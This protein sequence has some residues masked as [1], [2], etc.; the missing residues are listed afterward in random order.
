MSVLDEN[1]PA[2]QRLLLRKWRVQFRV[3]GV[4]VALSGTSDENLIPALARLGALDLFQPASQTALTL[5]LHKIPL[6]TFC[7]ICNKRLSG[8]FRVFDRRSFPVVLSQRAKRTSTTVSVAA[9]AVPPG[10]SAA[11]ETELNG[12]G[13]RHAGWSARRPPVRARRALLNRSGLDMDRSIPVCCRRPAGRSFCLHLAG[14]TL[15]GRQQHFRAAC[16]CSAGSATSGQ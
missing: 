7:R 4:D 5:T 10:A 14:S 6:T 9:L 16:L 13:S 11:P 1:V 3:I 2:G 12:P 8:A 15:T